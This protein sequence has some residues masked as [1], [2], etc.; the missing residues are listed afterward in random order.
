MNEQFYVQRSGPAVKLST[1]YSLVKMIFLNLI[2]LGIYG[3]V[4]YSRMGTELNT[5]ASRYDGKQ[6]MHY[7]LVYFLLSVIT[8]GIAH[9]VWFHK[10]SNRMGMELARRGIAYSFSAG[11]FWLW[12]VLGS[13]IVVGPFIY[14]HKLCTAMNLINT[15]YNSRG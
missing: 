7:C 4:I 15:N 11:D 13:F 6:T 1:N 10:L 5:A 8:L 9:I 12:N 14:I 3:I 2:T